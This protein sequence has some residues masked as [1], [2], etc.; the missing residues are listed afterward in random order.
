[1][2]IAA[3]IVQIMLGVFFIPEGIVKWTRI[4]PSTARFAHF[5]YPRWFKYVTGVW[6]M[7]VGIGLLIGLWVPFLAALA[8]LLLGVE[9]LVAIYSHLVRGKD[10]LSEILP[11]VV[12][13]LL[14]SFVLIVRAG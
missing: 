13:L 1:M 2:V 12:F 14:A 5:R 6:E 3:M 11:A 7:L 8:A 4:G 9:M 10:A